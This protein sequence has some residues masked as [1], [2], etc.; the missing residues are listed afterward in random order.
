MWRTDFW[1]ENRMKKWRVKRS[2]SELF[3][4]HGYLIDIIQLSVKN[5]PLDMTSLQADYEQKGLSLRQIATQKLHSRSTIQK[6]LKRANIRLR[7][8][9]HGHGNPAQ[10]RFGL[11]KKEGIV[12]AHKGEQ[13]IIAVIQDFRDDGLT[14][15]EIAQRLTALNIPSKNGKRK[16]HP[17]MVKRILDMF[18]K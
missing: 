5:Q 6:S 4:P 14:L 3:T 18:Q 12:S 13:L 11:K 8:S 10:L 15:R 9:S 1:I 16:W 17:M 7:A 2:S